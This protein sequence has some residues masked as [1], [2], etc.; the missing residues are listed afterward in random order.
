MF[1]CCMATPEVR[2]CWM[3]GHLLCTLVLIALTWLQDFRVI[4]ANQ[5]IAHPYTA[6]QTVETL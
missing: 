3:P 1:Y 6:I 5:D 4:Y 2:N